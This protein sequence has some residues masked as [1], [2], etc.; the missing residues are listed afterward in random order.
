MKRVLLKLSGEFLQGDQGIWSK[1][2]VD[3]I[4]QQIARLCQEGVQVAIVIGGGNIFRGGRNGFDFDR[5]E[6]DGIGMAAT[7]VNALFLKACL[8]KFGVDTVV[9]GRFLNGADIVNLNSKE[10]QERLNRGQVVIFSGGTGYAYFSTDTAAALRAIEIK[11]DVLLKGTKVDGVYDKD[12]ERYSDAKKFETLT[13]EEVCEQRYE[14]MDASAFSLCR[15]QK[16]PIFIFNLNQKDAIYN[17]VHHATHGTF[18]Q[19]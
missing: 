3:V 5:G 9:C 12:P 11:A 6:G 7:C 18:I 17:A 14:I 4:V 13:Y 10:L 8:Q 16:M 19:E 2:K 15:E 1:D